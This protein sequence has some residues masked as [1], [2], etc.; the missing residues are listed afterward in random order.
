MICKK[1]EIEITG[2]YDDAFCGGYEEYCYKCGEVKAFKDYDNFLDRQF[3]AELESEN[4]N[5]SDFYE[6]GDRYI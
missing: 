2:K 3:Q 4:P 6:I 5:F 1:C